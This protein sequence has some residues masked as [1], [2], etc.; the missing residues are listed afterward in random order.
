MTAPFLYEPGAGLSIAE[1]T[2]ARIDGHVVEIGDAFIPADAV[3]T[4]V[5]RAAS[6]A[7][8]IPVGCAAALTTAAWIH[9]ALSTPPVR[10][11]VQRARSHGRRVDR[12]A[13]LDYRDSLIPA[14]DLVVLGGLSVTTPT[15]T[16]ADLARC[17][18]PTMRHAARTMAATGVADP[19]AARRWLWTH[20]SLP[21]TGAAL[22]L[23]GRLRTT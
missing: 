2:A 17:P 23:L 5:L 14:E 12:S 7:A 10:L 3:E 22:R 21:H 13:R 8:A 19:D 20:A 1:L 15:R 18:D 11:S 9:G 6:L 4:P 16:L